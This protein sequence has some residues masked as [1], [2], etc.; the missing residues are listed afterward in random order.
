[1]VS[2]PIKHFRNELSTK[3]SKKCNQIQSMVAGKNSSKIKHS[4]LAA[5]ASAWRIY[6]RASILMGS[7]TSTSWF[8]ERRRS[9]TES[10]SLSLFW[11]SSDGLFGG[12]PAAWG[13]M[14]YRA[15]ATGIIPFFFLYHT[16]RL[17]LV[18]YFSSFTACFPSVELL[19]LA[20]SV[21]GNGIFDLS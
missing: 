20:H 21:S 17:I 11:I 5:A 2:N 9:S 1:M 15:D 18:T 12:V 4:K 16:P 6:T 7:A 3:L 19:N 10:S 13:P 8:Q 14:I